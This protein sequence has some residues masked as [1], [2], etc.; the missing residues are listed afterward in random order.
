[1]SSHPSLCGGPDHSSGTNMTKRIARVATLLAMIGW[2]WIAPQ[3]VLAQLLPP[4]PIVGASLVVNITEPTSGATVSGTTVPVTASVSVVGS[5]IV[6][7]VQFKLDGNNLGAE[8]TTRPYTISWNTT[9]ATNGS[10]TLTAVARALGS[11]ATWTSDPVTVRV[12]NPPTIS[13]FTPGSGPVG[14]S[15]SISGT[16]F[17]GASAVRFNGTSASFTVNSATTIT[18]TVPAGAATGPISATT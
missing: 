1:M 10:H 9:T 8:V 14:T 11:L 7:G 17:T 2:N 4:L 18:A 3:P 6:G 16:N 15:V 13:S 12:A 5:L